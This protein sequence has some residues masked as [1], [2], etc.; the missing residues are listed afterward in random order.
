MKEIQAIELGEYGLYRCYNY[1]GKDY[2]QTYLEYFN[3]RGDKNTL[4]FPLVCK[5]A[6]IEQCRKWH[7]LSEYKDIDNFQRYKS[8]PALLWQ[9]I[10]E[11]EPVKHECKNLLLTL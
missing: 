2:H 8:E 5:L 10:K 9:I 6:T 3:C 1:N 7:E 4:N 11:P